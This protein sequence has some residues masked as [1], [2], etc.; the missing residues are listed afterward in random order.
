MTV[1]A[2]G[3]QKTRGILYFH[4]FTGCDVVSAFRGKGKK[5]AWFTWDVCDEV[6]ETFVTFSQTPSNVFDNDLQ[7]L[8][9]FA[10]VLY[11]RTISGTSVDEARLELFA[12]KQKSYDAIPPSPAALRKH[13]KRAAY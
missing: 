5:S 1:P 11:D 9:R 8:E 13:A 10:I 2:F 12:R 6:T 7:N 3:P 4:T